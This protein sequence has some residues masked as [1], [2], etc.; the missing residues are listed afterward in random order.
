MICGILCNL[1]TI[2]D[3]YERAKAEPVSKFLLE[4]FKIRKLSSRVQLYNLIGCADPQKF[5]KVFDER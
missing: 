2:S 5:G 3:I 4:E 1:Q